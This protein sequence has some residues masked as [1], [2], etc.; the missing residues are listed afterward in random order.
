MTQAVSKGVQR[1]EAIVNTM[2]DVSK[3][4]T[5]TL[6]LNVSITPVTSIVQMAADDWAE[7]LKERKQS[8]TIESLEHLPPIV[9]DGERL[10]QVFSQ[11]IQNAIKY[12]PD[13]G[14]IR[15]AGRLLID[16]KLQPPQETIEI[17]VA[18]TGIGIAANDLE[19][20][21]EKFYRVGSASLHS[22][23]QTKFKGAGPGLGLTIAK[24]IVEALGG[25]I[26]V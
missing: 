9:A 11:L 6:D 16:D 1:L 4:D 7:A 10:K 17:V 8:L 15:V 26:W 23:G 5:E 22:T 20:L 21:F 19:H 13:E 12:T 18:D 24:G 14:Q 25:H 2:F 3:I